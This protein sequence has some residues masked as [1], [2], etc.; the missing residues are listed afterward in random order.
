M[1]TRTIN[2]IEYDINETE[3]NELY[4]DE[5]DYFE[6]NDGDLNSILDMFYNRTKSISPLSMVWELTEK[7]NFSCPFCYI[8][9][10]SISQKDTIES[11]WKY[12]FAD[13]KQI[14]DELIK[15]GL[16]ICYLTGGECL[17]HPDF[18]EIYK[19]LKSKGVLVVIL[20]N[21]SL[22]N[23]DHIK[24][25]AEYKP[26]RIEISLYGIEKTF[27]TKANYTASQVLKN[28]L[29]LKK[30][31]FNVV[32]K[33]P[34]NTCTEKEFKNVEGWCN[35]NNIEFYYSDEIFNAYD[36][37]DFSQYKINPQNQD[38]LFSS[39]KKPLEENPFGYKIAFDCSAGKHSFLLSADRMLRPC[40]AF[41]DI[42]EATFSI[43]NGFFKAYNEM[44][45]FINS[46]AGK[47]LSFCHGCNQANNCIECIATEYKIKNQNPYVAPQCN[48]V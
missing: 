22:I 29:T 40:F 27:E 19:Y 18:C 39:E 24:L 33:M 10:H 8:H 5:S 3:A 28:I 15:N 25:F 36:G 9:N 6:T 16:F 32:A 46:S 13:M 43:E 17:L 41:Y 35:N 14:L 47:I 23:K 20:T 4:F 26:Y 38:V 37:T 30:Q 1:I 7:C 12:R 34:L 48:N 2:T 21:G 44:T 42:P 11:Y 31:G 45:A